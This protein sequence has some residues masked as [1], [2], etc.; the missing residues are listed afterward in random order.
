MSRPKSCVLRGRRYSLAWVTNLGENDGK[1]DPPDWPAKKMRIK[2][3]LS[4]H[5]E[6]ETII[7]EALH[8]CLWDLDETAVDQIAHDIAR[9]LRRCGY[10]KK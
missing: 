4:E 2:L 7:H 3:G 5:A 6:M 8:G 10:G 9:L 1:C